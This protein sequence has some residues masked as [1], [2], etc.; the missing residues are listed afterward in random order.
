MPQIIKEEK[1]LYFKD[2]VEQNES[3]M[4]K[5]VNSLPLKQ[6]TLT[7]AGNKV[8]MPRLTSWHGEA[9]YKY[10]GK[11]F[12]PSPWTPELL[13]VKDLVEKKLEAEGFFNSV[14]VN[15]YR[16]GK[17]SISWH[18]DDEPEMDGYLIASISL[19][20]PRKFVIKNKATKQKT[21]L[22]L[23]CGDLLAMYNL[24]ENFEHSIPKQKNVHDSRMSL[25]FRKTK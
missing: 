18:S 19:G 24:Q 6:E 16:D 25:T 2:F 17:D 1:F 23:G 4:F 20:V 14:L 8:A 11:V 3:L 10:S 7:F 12:K 22:N 21:E 5:L 13:M 9:S 15:Y